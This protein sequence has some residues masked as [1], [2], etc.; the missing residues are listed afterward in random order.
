M[1]DSKQLGGDSSHHEIWRLLN[2]STSA[3]THTI[4]GS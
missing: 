3:A 2:T 1:D 4:T